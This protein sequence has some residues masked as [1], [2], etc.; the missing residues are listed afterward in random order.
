MIKIDPN[1]RIKSKLYLKKNIK[2]LLIKPKQSLSLQCK[3]KYK[4]L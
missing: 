4:R 2:I 3:I 1:N